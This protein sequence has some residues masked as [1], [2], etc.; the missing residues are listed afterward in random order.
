[1]AILAQEHHLTFTPHTWTNG[2][3]V[4]ANAHLVAGLAD[5]PFLEFPF[6]RPSGASRGATIC[7]PHPSRR[8]AGLDQPRRNTGMGY[9]LDEG[10]CSRRASA[11]VRCVLVI[12][13]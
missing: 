9:A 5:T 10:G 12:T 3:G 13:M 2:M 1:V 8:R 11:S 6:D 7:W 4:T